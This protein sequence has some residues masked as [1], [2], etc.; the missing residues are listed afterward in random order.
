MWDNYRYV[1][2]LGGALLLLYFFL[3][4][5]STR[6]YGYMGHD[7]YRSGPVIWYG[8]GTGH[9]Y[10]SQTVRTGSPGG[11]STRGGGISGGK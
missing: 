8:G 2:I 3:F 7:G 6:G 4:S 1:I 11:P 10:P 9:Y 5:C